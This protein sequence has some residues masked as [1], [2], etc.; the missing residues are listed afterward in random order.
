MKKTIPKV[1][2]GRLVLENW[3]SIKSADV[4]FKPLTLLVGQNS[5]GKS[6]LFQALLSLSQWAA[7]GSKAVFPM[8]GDIVRLGKFSDSLTKIINSSEKNPNIISMEIY[9]SGNSLRLDLGPG[10]TYS[11]SSIQN[12]E[13]NLSASSLKLSQALPQPSLKVVF[14]PQWVQ[15]SFRYEWNSDFSLQFEG[16][17]RQVDF[18]EPAEGI[19]FLNGLGRL[20]WSGLQPLDEVIVQKLLTIASAMSSASRR[21]EEEPRTVPVGDY[22]TRVLDAGRKNLNL[23]SAED[24]LNL[25]DAEIAK[26]LQFVDVSPHQSN[27]IL[28]RSNVD[29]V[30]RSHDFSQYLFPN[31][32]LGF[33]I[34]ELYSSPYSSIAQQNIAD[35]V[36]RF[37]SYVNFYVEEGGDPFEV[38]DEGEIIFPHFDTPKVNVTESLR[39]LPFLASLAWDGDGLDYPI[40]IRN[41]QHVLEDDL[42]EV[43]RIISGRISYLGPLRVNGFSSAL[44]GSFRNAVFPVGESGELT[45]LLIAELLS[46]S[47][48]REYPVFGEGIKECTFREA[49]E[50]WFGQFTIPGVPIQIVDLDKQGIQ[51]QIASRSLDRFGTGASQVLPI[52][53]LVL[54]RKP[55]DVVLI[56]QPELHLHPGGQQ[57]LAD[58]FMTA[59]SMGVQLILETHS[60]Y[61]VNRV[62]RGVVLGLI[63]S[64]S[65]QM[66]NFEQDY[67]GLAQVTGVD[68][69]ESGGFADWPRGFFANTEDDL[70]DIINALESKEE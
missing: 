37:T 52:L 18:D 46:D 41:P 58:L 49:L 35:E 48:V 12:F 53:A 28:F 1:T 43:D 50:S 27:D 24:F 29:T 66:V 34:E 25:L 26:V 22:L 13:A 59:T 3:K 60:E 30:L 57:Y 42:A 4:N 64:G 23:I 55:G 45:P 62:R 69:T 47:D 31:L 14:E 44:L 6:S 36:L 65:V 38:N 5:V 39:A 21:F 40:E 17:A 63:D 9:T 20:S 70:L 56:E 7:T 19:S 51:V 15:T 8:N 10:E 68:L 32:E 11:S 16:L 67:R 61:I 54:S 33:D 2:L